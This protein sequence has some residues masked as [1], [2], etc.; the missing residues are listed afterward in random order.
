[1]VVAVIALQL[2][3]LAGLYL[4]LRRRLDRIARGAG[5]LPELRSQVA[6][7]IAELNGTAERNISL[8]E[9]RIRRMDE[10]LRQA[11]RCTGRPRPASQRPAS[12]RPASQRPAS[13]RPASQR[14]ASQRPA[15]QRPASQHG[16]SAAQPARAGSAQERSAQVMRL[17]RLGFSSAVIADRLATSQGEVE[18]IVNLAADRSPALQQRGARKPAPRATEA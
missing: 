8:L 14:P 9:D 15:S 11:D 2:A 10:L 3:G 7:L 18:L 6:E 5:D 12:Q 16:T 4:V 13:Q 1:V 17:R